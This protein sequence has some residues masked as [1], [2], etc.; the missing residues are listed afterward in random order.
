MTLFGITVPMEAIWIIVAV[1]VLVIIAL[2][3]NLKE[4]IGL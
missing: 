1:I 4:K 3:I 2:A